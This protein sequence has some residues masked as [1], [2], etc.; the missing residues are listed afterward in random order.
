MH[1]LAMD[2]RRQVWRTSAA[3]Q[4]LLSRAAG[5]L[6]DLAAA[7]RSGLKGD[8]QQTAQALLERLAGAVATSSRRP[9][10]KSATALH[11]DEQLAKEAA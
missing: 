5:H 6:N 2:R 1:R 11:Q 8:E 9:I 10:T 7:V 4:S 3:G